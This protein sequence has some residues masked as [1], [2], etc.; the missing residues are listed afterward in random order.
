MCE[1]FVCGF[2]A[3]AACVNII[4]FGETAYVYTFAT[5][6]GSNKLLWIAVYILT[7]SA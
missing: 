6:K 7:H 1:L 3:A 5:D 4:Y 2:V